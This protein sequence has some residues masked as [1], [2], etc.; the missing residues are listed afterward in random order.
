MAHRS[1]GVDAAVALARKLGGSQFD[2]NVAARFS[3]AAGDILDGLDAAS[4][5][6]EVIAAAPGAR[7]PVAW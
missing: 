1:G 4:T 2:P 7:T 5:W 6:D 3:S